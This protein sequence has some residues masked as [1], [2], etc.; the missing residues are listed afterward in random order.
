[1]GGCGGLARAGGGRH[2][3]LHSPDNHVG[4]TKMH[5]VIARYKVKPDRAEENLELVRAV[6]DEL[7]RTKPAGLRYATFLLDDGVSFVHI[8]QTDAD[9]NPLPKAAAFQAFQRGDRR[10]LRGAAAGER[11]TVDRRLPFLGW[12]RKKGWAFAFPPIALSVLRGNHPRV[13]TAPA[14]CRFRTVARSSVGADAYRHRDRARHN[15]LPADALMRP[16]ERGY[17]S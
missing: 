11:G 13:A 10:P 15:S 7:E 17:W 14:H 3:G 4:G 12:G 9:P 8:A 6:Y 1:G 16:R 2:E 5:Q